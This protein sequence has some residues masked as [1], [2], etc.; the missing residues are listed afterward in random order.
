VTIA[1]A[2]LL[3]TLVRTL[4]LFGALVLVITLS[5][6]TRWGARLLAGPLRDPQGDVLVVLGSQSLEDGILNAHSYWRSVYAVRAWR[7]GGFRHLLLSGGARHG[8][9][10][11]VA[12]REFLLANGVPREAIE[13]ET[14]SLSTRENA[15]AAAPILQ[16]IPGHKVLLTSDY[17]MFRAAGCFR[18]AGVQIE[19]RPV[20]DLIKQSVPV[21]GRWGAFC[22]LV[23]E[24]VKIAY[25][26]ARGWI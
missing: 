25:Y 12:M 3:Q 8:T 23:E 15:L 7:Q 16:R 21:A 10:V 6:A 4:A 2:P 9:P 19:S 13:V 14:G 24:S 5:G 11:A 17:H 20:P 1:K 18:A 22:E 26:F